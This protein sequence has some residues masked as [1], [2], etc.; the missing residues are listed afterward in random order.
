MEVGLTGFLEILKRRVGEP[1]VWDSAAAD[2][3]RQFNLWKD[4]SA[5][6]KLYDSFT[7]TIR[8]ANKSAE[9]SKG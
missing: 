5:R 3:E 7:Q 6:K 1:P 4:W 9:Q 2:Q 8:E